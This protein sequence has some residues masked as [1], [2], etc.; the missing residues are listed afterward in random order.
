MKQIVFLLLIFPGILLAQQSYAQKNGLDLV[1]QINQYVKTYNNDSVYWIYSKPLNPDWET[2]LTLESRFEKWG[3]CENVIDKFAA[4]VQVLPFANIID[5]KDLLR[6]IHQI[7]Q[8][9]LKRWNNRSFQNSQIKVLKR[10]IKLSSPNNRKN[11]KDYFEISPPVFSTDEQTAILQINHYC[12]MECG[13][14]YL[15]ILRNENG[16]WIKIFQK[17]L[18]IS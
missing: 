10:K 13:D 15:F 11:I 2:L 6:M 14:G 5:E 17:L 12:G 4:D 18:W 1:G 9:K 8:Q 16:V 7:D 3:K